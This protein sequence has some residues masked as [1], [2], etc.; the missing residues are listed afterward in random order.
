MQAKSYNK[1]MS[2]S[3]YV[4]NLPLNFIKMH[5]LGN[6]FVIFDWRAVDPSA[7]RC[8]LPDQARAL[9]NRRTG[10]GC[11]QVIILEPATDR[12]ADSFMRIH[13]ADG[14]EVEA[15]GNALRCVA[16][17]LMAETDRKHV[18]VETRAGL[19][20]AEARSQSLIAVDMGQARLDWRDIPLAE[21]VDTLHLPISVAGYCDPVAVNIGNPHM[22]F[23]VEDSAAV[24]IEQIGPQLE[25]HP[26]FPERANI[27]F[28]ESL[29][30]D[31]LRMRV[32]ER[33]VGVTSACGTGACAALVAAAQRGIS[34]RAAELILEGGMLYIEWLPDN[35]VLMTGPTAHSFT[36][37]ISL[38][39]C[40]S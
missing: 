35:H 16:A 15:C 5:G 13:N 17:H 21:P 40:G 23:F 1:N 37:S 24:P 12:L 3:E 8:L 32:W 11:D 10:I 38:P 14:S 7:R 20:D 25:C 34:Q 2:E 30:P 18:I 26:L 28:V 29:A 33:G 19:L 4:S 22:V 6:D 27:E 36:G 39:I 31:R 9:A